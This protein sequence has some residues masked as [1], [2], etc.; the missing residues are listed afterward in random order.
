MA[1]L[2]TDSFKGFNGRYSV[3]NNCS[4]NLQHQGEYLNEECILVQCPAAA[5]A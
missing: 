2:I 5:H 3:Y 4:C 1:S